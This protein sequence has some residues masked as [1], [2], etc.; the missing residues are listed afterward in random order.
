M[1]ELTHTVRPN[2]FAK[3]RTYRLGDDALTWRD[4]D[5][6]GRLA[7]S[8]VREVRLTADPSFGKDRAQ[9]I[10]QDR[11]GR[12]V[13]LVSKHFAGLGTLED[14]LRTYAPLVRALLPRVAAAAPQAKFIAGGTAQWLLWLVL[15]TVCA[16]AVIS[17]VVALLGGAPVEG[18]GFAILIPLAILGPGMWRVVR[19][20]RAKEFDGANPPA[21]LLGELGA[22]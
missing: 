12:K 14:R 20:G 9:C 6:G 10:V 7:F 11:E 2:F 17:L 3:E 15:G 5:G 13:K 21:E 18:G 16:I 22:P 19:R 8:D 4:A 1:T